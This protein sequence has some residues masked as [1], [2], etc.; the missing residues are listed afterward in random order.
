MLKKVSTLPSKPFF[1][2]ITAPVL[3]DQEPR[4]GADLRIK[5][6]CESSLRMPGELNLTR[7]PTADKAA[8]SPSLELSQSFNAAS[9]DLNGA[10]GR[11]EVHLTLDPDRFSAS[12]TVIRYKAKSR[13]ENEVRPFFQRADKAE[14]TC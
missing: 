9:W 14:L 5:V 3:E 6:L 13:Y 12:Q 11:F 7:T 1:L 10:T 8:T 4:E 2:S